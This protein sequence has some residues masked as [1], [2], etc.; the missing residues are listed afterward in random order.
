MQDVCQ[1]LAQLHLQAI[2]IALLAE[3]SGGIRR[4]L[5][6]TQWRLH[7]MSLGAARLFHLKL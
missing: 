4:R 7:L 2:S 3:P 5:K 6:S 1:I